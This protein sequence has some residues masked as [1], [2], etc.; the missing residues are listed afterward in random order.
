MFKRRIE[1]LDFIFH[2]KKEHTKKSQRRIIP[3]LMKHF[4]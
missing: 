3:N 4:F 2:V 1:E